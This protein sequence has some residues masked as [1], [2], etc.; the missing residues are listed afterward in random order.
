MSRTR[1]S[2]ILM[3]LATVVPPANDSRDSLLLPR[4]NSNP[5]FNVG[6][7][8]DIGDDDDIVG[9]DIESILS[10]DDDEIGYEEI[11]AALKARARGKRRGNGANAM[12]RKLL[13]QR[14]TIV[15]SK[16]PTKSRVYVLSLDTVTT[17][18]AGATTP[19]TAQPQVLF[20]PE[21]L[22]IDS[23]VAASFLINT[24]TIGKNSQ[25][26]STGAVPAS[27]FSPTAVGV[28]LKLDTAQ[29]SA[30]VA[31]SV[32]NTSGGALRFTAGLI[33]EAVE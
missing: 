5:D 23:T 8:Y 22:V 11:A 32:T 20:R 2:T 12:A 30:I 6:A 26:A 25:F 13:A 31:L 29:I 28:T 21:R 9:D 27:M 3:S 7:L 15:R 10:G 33:G 19:V 4:R 1:L 14:G 18:A 24:F 16:E 17:V